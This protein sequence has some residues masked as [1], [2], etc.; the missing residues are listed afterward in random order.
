MLEHAFERLGCRRVELKTDAL[1]ERSRG[2]MEALPAQFEGVHRK[3]MLV[4]GGREPRLGLVQR[5]RRRV[6]RGAGEP[7]TPAR[8]ATRNCRTTPIASRGGRGRRRGPTFGVPL[9]A[10]E[11]GR[12]R[13][14]QLLDPGD[15]RR[16][17]VLAR[18]HEHR[19][20]DVRRVRS[21]VEVALAGRVPV[22]AQRQVHLDPRDRFGG[23][24][25]AR[26]ER[27]ADAQEL[28]EVALGRLGEVAGGDLAGLRAAEAV[29]LAITRVW[30]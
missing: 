27:H 9:V 15:R 1:N 14:E 3:H 26:V 11:L 6:A 21:D 30:T 2:A 25:R 7:P 19:A 22:R 17:I 28:G 5:D 29:E 23:Q 12:Q 20:A 18:E 16:R 24:R 4:R 13:V 10:D 8:S